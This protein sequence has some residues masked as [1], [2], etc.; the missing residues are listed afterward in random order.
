MSRIEYQVLV[1]AT[2]D[3][4]CSGGSLAEVSSSAAMARSSFARRCLLCAI[5][6]QTVSVAEAG[7]LSATWE[8]D[9]YAH[10]TVDYHPDGVPADQVFSSSSDNSNAPGGLSRSAVAVA[11]ATQGGTSA[12]GETVTIIGVSSDFRSGSFW[13][14]SIVSSLIGLDNVTFGSEGDGGG[15]VQWETDDNGELSFAYAF[16]GDYQGT[17]AGIR[18]SDNTGTN[19]Y[20]IE[21]GTVGR[22][23]QTLLGVNSA[24]TL[25]S[26]PAVTNPFS[27][28]TSF[29]VVWG[30]GGLPGLSA[31]DSFMPQKSVSDGVFQF[32]IPVMQDYGI[33][34]MLYF[35]P[36]FATGYE[37]R[38]DGSRFASFT[39]PDALPGGDDLFQLEFQGVLY[40]LMAGNVFDFTA[41]DPF[42]ASQFVL[43]GID[44]SEMVDPNVNPPFVSGLSFTTEGIANVRQTALTSDVGTVTPE[45]TSLA[46]AGF[47]GLGMAI[48]AW[49]RRRQERSQAV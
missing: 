31:M 36:V 2:S 34:N 38:V 14:H 26:G 23:T 29:A 12:R 20:S 13:S 43:R 44:A 35:D 10:A 22:L 40:D 32:A 17:R 45:P 6:V 28:Q 42:G 8:I 25:Q 27:G 33:G 46:L 15:H 37:Y 9:A 19:D 48:G 47:A 18:V 3:R 49:R 24:I 39:I 30:R 1:K 41:I 21:P 11:V 7:I 4:S 5:I 16:E